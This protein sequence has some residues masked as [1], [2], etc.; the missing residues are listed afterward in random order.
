MN[1]DQTI[2]TYWVDMQKCI[3]KTGKP[4]PAGIFEEF[5]CFNNMDACDV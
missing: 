4:I 2:G 5:G 1:K 3:S